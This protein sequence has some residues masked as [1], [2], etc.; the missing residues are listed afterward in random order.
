MVFTLN[1]RN[2]NKGSL[3]LE[4]AIS[5]P[6][7]ICVILSIAF[8]TRIVIL[9]NLMQHA[10]NDT[11]NEI[12]TYSYLYSASQL[13]EAHDNTKDKIEEG[14]VTFSKHLD[15]TLEI[16]KSLSNTSDKAGDLKDSLDNIG[17]V[18]QII[19]DTKD[20]EGS[21]KNNEV[22]AKKAKE[23]ISD[24]SSDPKKELVSMAC[25]MADGAFEDVK[26][27]LIAVPLTKLFFKKHL[28]TDEMN[29]DQRLKNLNV[30]DGFDGLDFS[31]STIFK[32]N[33]SIDIIVR[34][35]IKTQLPINFLPDI[36]FIQRTTVRAWLDG[37]GTS[38]YEPPAEE[39]TTGLWDMVDTA[40]R[41][42]EIQKL[43]GRN[44]PG[45]FPVITKYD[46]GDAYMIRSI[47]LDAP[48]YL[49]TSNV[50]SK[51]KSF[52]KEFNEFQ[53][54]IYQ[55]KEINM[56]SRTLI[57]VVPEGTSGNSQSIIDK[58]TSIAES[59][60]IKLIIKEGYGRRAN[61]GTA[62]TGTANTGTG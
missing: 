34:Y 18:D 54:G 44:L 40:Q 60:G 56:T 6:V 15:T 38:K 22:D 41:G 4:A 8:L 11:A 10:I 31:E 53:D 28:S 47:D 24:I 43:E 29:A 45:N 52:I 25:L 30:V 42:R 26:S 58:Y 50:E 37:D 57:I 12:A 14:K 23:I 21:L 19:N 33:K 3:T 48:T 49:K 2:K 36:Y 32:D 7:F 9:H 5:L 13:Q 20:L 61:T 46:D 1:A 39:T 17:N 27:Q 62:N 51:I 55:G 59:K 35:K 16:Y